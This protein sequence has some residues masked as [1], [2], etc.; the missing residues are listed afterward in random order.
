MVDD[1]VKWEAALSGQT[2]LCFVAVCFF[3][4]FLFYGNTSPHSSLPPKLNWLHFLSL[5]RH[6]C[7]QMEP[8]C[9]M[10]TSKDVLIVTTS[11]SQ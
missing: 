7:P 11:H 9:L 10:S 5:C 6:S 2:T 3:V 4:C 1:E 8:G